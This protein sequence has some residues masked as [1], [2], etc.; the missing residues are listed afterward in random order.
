M[1][2]QHNIGFQI[3]IIVLSLFFSYQA[4]TTIVD[5]WHKRSIIDNAKK[6][7]SDLTH[8]IDK[9]N[10]QLKDVQSPEYMERVARDKFGYVKDGEAI[11][12]MQGSPP[13]VSQSGTTVGEW[14]NVP[15]WKKWWSLFF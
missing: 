9:L 5:L 8:D 14:D 2:T 10:R 3:L 7:Y 1:K 12:L 4:L 13:S 11:V 15:N 6:Q